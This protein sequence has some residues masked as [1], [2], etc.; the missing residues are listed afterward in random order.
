MQ[1][2]KS[3]S[4]NHIFEFMSKNDGYG[5]NQNLFGIF[6]LPFLSILVFVHLAIILL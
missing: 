5:K 3:Q 2:I 6:C 4:I 1:I